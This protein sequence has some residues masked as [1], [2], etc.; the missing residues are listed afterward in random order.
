MDVCYQCRFFESVP[1]TTETQPAATGEPTDAEVTTISG[2]VGPGVGRC[3]I[4]GTLVT[5]MDPVCTAGLPR[6]TMS[7]AKT[8]F[9][10]VGDLVLKAEIGELETQKLQLTQAK[11]LEM[12]AH[13][14]TKK[15][16]SEAQAAIA[17]KDSELAVVQSKVSRLEKDRNDLI[18]KLDA[19]TEVSVKTQVKVDT[20]QSDLAFYKEDVERKTK[21]VDKQK[22]EVAELKEELAKTKRT[23]NDESAKRAEAMQRAEDAEEGRAETSRENALLSE[24]LSTARQTNYDLSLRLASQAKKIMGLERDGR[25]EREAHRKVVEELRELKEKYGKLKE[26]KIKKITIKT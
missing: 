18:E 5:T 8:T 14:N 25:E 15:L 9:E 17:R 20:L 4:T 24:D 11:N 16:L 23:A 26:Q 1:Y 2:G 21:I 12:E 3:R 7:Q 6:E 19:A 13:A 10:S 22:V